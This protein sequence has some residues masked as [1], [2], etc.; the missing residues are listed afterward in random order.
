MATDYPDETTQRTALSRGPSLGAPRTAC[1][2]VIHGPGIGNRV[3][4]ADTRISVGRS[5]QTDLHIPHAS[6]SRRHCEFWRSGDNYFVRDLGSTNR[7]RL[8]ELPIEVAELADGDHVVLG[9]VILKFISHSSVEAGYHEE[10]YQL[11]THDALTGLFNRRQFSDLLASEAA[12]GMRREPHTVLAIIDVDHFK[13]INDRFGHLEGDGVLKKLADILRSHVRAGDV[14][15]RIGGEEFAVLMA[16]TDIEQAK[17]FAERVREAVEASIF[18]PG[19]EPQTMTVSVGLAALSKT[20][21]EPTELM[22]AADRALY[23]AK[24]TGRNRVCCAP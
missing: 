6:I 23:A 5:P 11:A 17:L 7:T 16:D 19:A 18:T 8:N 15:A 24:E 12:R 13:R 10:I 22:R 3:D 14:L 1:V 9:D 4:I 20:R 2:V 21:R